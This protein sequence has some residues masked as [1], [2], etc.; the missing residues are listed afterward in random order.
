[1]L[2][3]AAFAPRGGHYFNTYGVYAAKIIGDYSMSYSPEADAAQHEQQDESPEDIT[4]PEP[5]AYAYPA[6]PALPSK[7]TVTELKNRAADAELTD[8]SDTKHVQSKRD[9]AF[10]RP[11]FI[12]E[13]AAL[14]GAARGTALHLALRRLELREYTDETDMRASIDALAE[15]GLLSKEQADAAEAGVLLRFFRSELGRRVI[16]SKEVF[17][18]FKFSLLTPAEQ[19]FEGGGE[20]E[21][22]FQGVVDLAFREGDA[23]TIVD[24]KSDRV[25]GEDDISEK[26]KLYAPQ[27]RA[28]A[29]AM[30]RV[31]DMPVKECI[32]YFF[33]Q[34][35]NSY[36]IQI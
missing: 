32:L 9:T 35:G 6:A 21:I 33:A 8:E 10:A 4:V 2:L 26:K 15:R 17:R 36:S 3:L 18:E 13:K 16:A 30:K 25:S 24:F 27:L 34:T 5:I 23:L 28:Y 11:R 7:L 31:T 22:L 29:E 1:V 19:F 12:T 20:D 14:T